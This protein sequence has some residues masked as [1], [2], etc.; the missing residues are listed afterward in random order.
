MPRHELPPVDRRT[1]ALPDSV[2]VRARFRTRRA[3]L[4][5]VLAGGLALSAC[6]SQQAPSEGTTASGAASDG[7]SAAS[8]SESSA[9][10]EAGSGQQAAGLLPDEQ[11][12]AAAEE[13]VSEMTLEEKAGQVLL[14]T[15]SGADPASVDAQISQIEDLHLG[16]VIVM[17]AN[18][19]TADGQ[20]TT[21]EAGAGGGASD[22][23]VEAMRSQN[24]R[25]GAALS[26]EERSWSGIIGVDQ[27][28]GSVARLAEPL[29]VWPAAQTVGAADDP[30]LTR[31][32]AAG[33]GAELAGLGFTMDHAPVAD[34]TT[35][36]DAVIRDRA[37][38]D[39]P[40]V[41]SEQAVAAVGGLTDAGMISSPKHFPGHGSVST[42][43]HVGLPVQEASL[44]TLAESEWLP[45]Q[46][47][48]DA[49]APSIMMGHIAVS[50]WSAEVPASLEPKAYEALREDLGFQGAVVTDALDMGALKDV[51]GPGRPVDTG[52]STPAGAAL[53]A[54]ADLLVMPEDEAAA[55]ADIVQAVES[56]AIPQQ[57][58]DE[59]ATRVVAMQ[60]SYDQY[61]DSAPVEPAEPGSHR[62]L[63]ARFES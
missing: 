30:G 60:M 61:R 40:E 34:V 11:T 43:S 14:A 9:R 22:V 2:A 39:D 51:V 38:S 10:S 42:D 56:G 20:G 55:H 31:Q 44:E 15:W 37:Y 49:G 33:M 26:P 32:A 57:R 36:S 8:P 59:A 47:V 7:A 58:L 4:G 28:G 50:Q 18:V 45:F 46:A 25:V 5:L 63:A 1:P 13:A 16:G 29:T 24:E 53:Q 48:I 19:P 21:E 41:V 6:G 12:R 23:D 27:E 35:P 3:G 52:V 62:E 17:G 54:G